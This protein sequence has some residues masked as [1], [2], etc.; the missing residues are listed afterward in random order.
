VV[1]PSS[2][3]LSFALWPGAL[4]EPGFVI[5]FRAGRYH[6]VEHESW[7]RVAVDVSVPVRMPEEGLT[8]ISVTEHGVPALRLHVRR[9]TVENLSLFTVIASNGAAVGGRKSFERNEDSSF[10]QCLLEVTPV[11]GAQFAPKPKSVGTAEPDDDQRAAELI[12]RD[13]EEYAVGH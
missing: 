4:G 10:F 3:G 6:R 13:V 5:R 8:E 11:Q 1:R 12:Y 7:R 9:K 2:A